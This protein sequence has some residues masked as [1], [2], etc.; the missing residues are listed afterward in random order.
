M[1][2]LLTTMSD[3]T[4]TS[5]MC[6]GP[7]TV[8]LGLSNT[9]LRADVWAGLDILKAIVRRR[10]CRWLLRCRIP[11]QKQDDSSSENDVDVAR[12]RQMRWQSRDGRKGGWV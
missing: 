1:S 11:G 3:A 8:G 5:G 2:N 6:F 9:E 7:G 4:C 12:L 10:S